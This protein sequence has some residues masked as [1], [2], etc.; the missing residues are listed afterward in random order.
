VTPSSPR[1][2][3]EWLVASS[4]GLVGAQLVVGIVEALSYHP[5]AAQAYASEK[6]LRGS[7][8]GAV[9]AGFH[10]WGSAALLVLSML[11]VLEMVLNEGYREVGRWYAAIGLAV[12]AFV[13]QL[14][15]N[16]LPMDRHGVQ[17]AVVEAGVAGSAPVAG[18]RVSEFMLAGNGFND[19]TI[20]L[21]WTGHAY[22]LPLGAVLLSLLLIRRGAARSAAYVLAPLVVLV[23][24]IFLRAPLGNPATPADYGQFNAHVSWYT[25]PLHAMLSAFSRI[26]PR[27][28][29]V[30]AILV[31]TA[32]AVGLLAMPWIG[33]RVTYI[34]VRGL[35]L[36]VLATFLVV[37]GVFGGPIAP[38]IGNRDPAGEAVA[39]KPR[40]KSTD[41]NVLALV[42][43]GRQ[44]FNSVG[45][46]DCHGKDGRK[47]DSGPDLS[48]EYKI[49]PDAAWY[50]GLIRNPKS[51][52][53]SAT[54]P[55]FPNLTDAQLKSIGT[56]L[57]EPP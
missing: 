15:G 54:M 55:A 48:N 7:L 12:V 18:H 9:G 36:L 4:A 35:T 5:V 14:T 49:H 33:K 21:W 1:P 27:A 28:A 13:F 19:S 53:P 10:Y 25:W 26:S 3:R 2:L 29:W 22:I 43:R 34:A 16:L 8:L 31:P 37:G 46:S 50:G 11:L 30:G 51:V 32:I 6:A 52:N 44:D 56:F 41:P 38:L 40:V 45:C 20:S 17:T 23:L 39:V 57:S 42:A 47:G 24:A